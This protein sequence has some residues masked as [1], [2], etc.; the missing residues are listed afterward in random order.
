MKMKGYSLNFDKDGSAFARLEGVNASFKDLSAVCG[1]IRR[2]ETDWVIEFLEKAS[3]GE[4]PVRYRKHNKKL[5]HRRELGGKKGRY[6]KKAAKIILKVLK[7]A[8]ANGLQKGLG[9][10]YRVFHASATK[11]QIYPRMA[12]KGRQARSYLETARVEIVLTPFDI[13]KKNKSINPTKKKKMVEKNQNKSKKA[14][15]DL[16][17]QPTKKLD[18][19]KNT[20]DVSTKKNEVK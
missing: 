4:I 6:P 16:E 7:S 8:I 18:V 10:T 12:P 19:S 14:K 3:K 5:G 1:N 15:K 13:T 17:K 9:E 2:K 20:K 11:K